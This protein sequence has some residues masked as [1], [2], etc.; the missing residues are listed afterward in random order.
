MV[1]EVLWQGTVHIDPEELDNFTKQL[2]EFN[3]NLGEEIR[4]LTSFIN[5]L[6]KPGRSS[7]SKFAQEFEQL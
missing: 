6:E 1:L 3:S 5:V 7:I 4:R 2:G